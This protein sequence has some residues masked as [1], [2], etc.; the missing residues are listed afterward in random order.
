MNP[1]LH[2]NASSSLAA[3][4]LAKAN[5]L[6]AKSMAKLSS[7]SR[8]VEPSDDAAGVAL[9]LKMGAA[10]RRQSAV[11][12]NITNALSL[13]QTQA[14]SLSAVSKQLTRMSELAVL[15]QD[16]TKTTEDLDNYMTELNQL[17]QEMGRTFEDRFNGTDLLFYQGVN[18][19]LTVYLD[20]AGTQTMTLDRSDFSANTGWGILVGTTKPYS[21]T[22]GA[23]DTPANLINETLWGSSSFQILIQDLATMISVNGAAQSRLLFALDSVRNQQVNFE[24]AVSRMADTDVAAETSKL[25]RSNVLVQSGASMVSQANN[26]ANTLLKLIEG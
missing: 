16:V 24:Q 7:G 22:V 13:M 4:N 15:M 8:L 21:G 5:L 2:T 26:S 25:A 23:T 6:Q 19:P 18:T 14:A 11:E 10:V 9:H 3:L 17:R 1:T 12:T 20:E